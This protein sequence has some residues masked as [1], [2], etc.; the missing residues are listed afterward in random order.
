MPGWGDEDEGKGGEADEGK[1]RSVIH[2]MP[3]AAAA[4]APAA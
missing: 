1:V 3:A 4:A 2:T